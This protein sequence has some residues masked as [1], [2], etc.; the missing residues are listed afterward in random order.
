MPVSGRLISNRTTPGCGDFF[1]TTVIGW[2]MT[3]GTVVGRR[4]SP[5]DGNPRPTVG[6][7]GC[8]AET[9]CAVAHDL[10]GD[11]VGRRRLSHVPGVHRGRPH[12]HLLRRR[13]VLRDRADT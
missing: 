12:H 1:A 6:T 7:R 3:P 10:G 9:T 13:A 11:R 8:H 4:P 5:G 2:P